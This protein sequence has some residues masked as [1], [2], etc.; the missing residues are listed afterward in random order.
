[1]NA[2]KVFFSFFFIIFL[3][4]PIQNVEANNKTNIRVNGSLINLDVEPIISEG[5]TLVPAKAVLEALYLD[6]SFD[7]KKIY[8]TDNI[9]NTIELTIGS[10]VAI[11]NND[12]LLLDVPPKSISGS[13]LIPIR[14]IAERFGLEVNWNKYTKV[15]DINSPPLYPIRVNDKWG[16]INKNGETI[17]P[18]QFSS[19]DHVWFKETKGKM[20]YYAFSEGLAAVKVDDKWG[21]I[22]QNGNMVIEPMFES[23]SSFSEDYAKVG[24]GNDRYKYINRKGEFITSTSFPVSYNNTIFSEGFAIVSLDRGEHLQNYINTKGNLISDKGYNP[25]NIFSEGLAAVGWNDEKG[26]YYA[27]YINQKGKLVLTGDY[28]MHDSFSEGLAPVGYGWYPTS[29][30]GFIDKTG[31]LVIPLKFNHAKPFSEGIARVAVANSGNMMVDPRWGFIDKKGRLI[32]ELKYEETKDFYNG[33]AQV[34]ENGRWKYI[35]KEGEKIST[36]EFD[37]TDYFYEGL[38]CVKIEDKWGF[39]NLKGEMV[40]EPQYD[41]VEPFH[42]GLAK[43]FTYIDNRKFSR[44]PFKY[45]NKKGQVVWDSFEQ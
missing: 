22:N 2:K 41:F 27:G 13:T 21:Y 19:I 7:N 5:R 14:F 37:E 6:V 20:G 8:I 16:F 31:K 23:A 26:N 36:L 10:K 38:A 28:K 4:L 30:F 35:N 9:E 15:I 33:V 45:I 12:E 17:V 29:N 32:T 25:T 11:I 40:I 34:K 1:M 3:L 44:A 43:V 24:I 42:N 18:V 39:I